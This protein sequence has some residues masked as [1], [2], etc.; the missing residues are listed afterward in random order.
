MQN[1]NLFASKTNV[2]SFHYF[3][4]SALLTHRSQ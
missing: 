4:I 2:Q 1:Y 3:S